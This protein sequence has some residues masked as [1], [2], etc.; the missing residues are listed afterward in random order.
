MT[1]LSFRPE[2]ITLPVGHFL[3][4]K[5]VS[6]K[7]DIAVAS[8]GNGCILGYIPEAGPELVNDAAQT[9]A[10][11]QH[12]SGWATCAPRERAR[13]LRRWADLVE[14]HAME[15]ARLETVCSTRPISQT[16]GWDIPFLAEGIRF[17]SEYC[18][19]IG[20]DVAATSASLLG[21]TVYEPYGVTGAIAPWNFPLVMAS[22]KVVPSLAAGNG[23]VLKPSEMTPFSVVRLA[24]LAGEA[25]IP[26]GLFNVVQGT[27]LATGEAICRHPA[28]GKLSFTGSTRT[29]IA[30]MKAAAE[31]GPKPVT[32][33]LGGKS[34]QLVF[35]DISSIDEVAD[36][37]FR[38]FTGNAGQ[39]CVTGSRL[40]VQRGVAEPLIEALL[41]L[42]SRVAALAPWEESA[43]YSPI[44]SEVQA[45]RILNL[46]EH[47][48]KGGAQSLAPCLRMNSEEGGVFLSPGILL[49]TDVNSSVWQEEVFGPVLAVQI[50]DEDDEAFA[51]AQHSVYGLAAGV[52][53]ASMARAMRAIRTL[54]AGTVW[55]NRYGRSSDFVIPTGGFGGSG[56]GKD[57]GRQAFEANLRLKSVLMAAG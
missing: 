31:S 10:R 34:P 13:V 47:S 21:M 35:D 6:G 41:A 36:R 39:V 14:Q 56:I 57:L 9:A 40:I 4:G 49:V 44:I 50:F 15:L 22:W 1:N 33:E 18:D 28:I 51:L 48:I 30:V 7:K 53:T 23:T 38:A 3:S 20:G 29:G 37:I 27:G 16:I 45:Q 24:Q 26:A 17:F 5:I 42:C 32:L 54:K 43:S 8:P 12:E 2:D 11:V 25:G 52:H 55:V 46:A 19:K